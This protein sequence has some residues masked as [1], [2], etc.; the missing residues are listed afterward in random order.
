M[1]LRITSTAGKLGETEGEQIASRRPQK[2][3]FYTADA[4]AL[5]T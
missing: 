3:Q 1:M 4:H 5:V 2:P